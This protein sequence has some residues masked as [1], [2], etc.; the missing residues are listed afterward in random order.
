MSRKNQEA[1]AH[2]QLSENG[3]AYIAC[4]IELDK[5]LEYLIN[6]LEAAGK[7][8]QTVICMTA[9][10]YPYGM[11]E[12]QYEELAGR[13][14]S[15]NKDVFRNM[16]ILWNAQMEDET[17][18]VEKVCGPMDVLPTLL[19]LFGFSYDSRFYA[20]RDILSPEEG[21]VIFNDRSFVTD[22]VFYERKAKT[23]VWTADIGISNNSPY[24]GWEYPGGIVLPPHSKD[25]NFAG[26][27]LLESARDT[28][29][30]EKK[31]ELKD[32]YNFSAYILQKDYY[33]ILKECVLTP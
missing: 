21:M 5:A 13:D 6:E 10:H 33:K 29:M 1:V 8:D 31:Q 20:G 23:T 27:D 15:T 2:L 4:H 11:T 18:V 28:Y 7:L 17:V 14:L 30:E 25:V 19:N 3:Q 22:T 12:E 24:I 32:R 9:D 26:G 16:L